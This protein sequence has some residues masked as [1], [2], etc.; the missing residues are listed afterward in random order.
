MKNKL[1]R[2]ERMVRVLG[3]MRR[4]EDLRMVELKRALAER[5]AEE[6]RYVA[7]LGEVAAGDPRFSRSISKGLM[8]V[9][10]NIQVARASIE[11]QAQVCLASGRKFKQAET[12]LAGVER[13]WENIRA[14]K[15]LAEVIERSVQRSGSSV[16]QGAGDSLDP[17][18]SNSNKP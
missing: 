4:R 8:R 7:A 1:E 18:S 15:E 3:Q 13:D 16:G 17:A 14:G 12:R 2:A 9:S 5:E 11:K 10:T 6:V